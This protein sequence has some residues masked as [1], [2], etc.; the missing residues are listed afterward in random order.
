MR[1]KVHQL[2]QDVRSAIADNPKLVYLQR[3]KDDVNVQDAVLQQMASIRQQTGVTPKFEAVLNDI[4]EQ[5]RVQM[6]NQHKTY[7]EIQKAQAEG[8]QGSD[9]GSQGSDK[10]SQKPAEDKGSQKP[11]ED[12]G[13]Q[14]SPKKDDKPVFK[15]LS[16]EEFIKLTEDEKLT[17]IEEMGAY[18]EAIGFN[19]FAQQHEKADKQADKTADKQHDKADKQTDKADKQ[20][21]KADKQ[22]DKQEDNSQTLGAGD[23]EN[24]SKPKENLTEDQKYN[25]DLKKWGIDPDASLELQ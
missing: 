18:E 12:K 14:P 9:K 7:T 21:D 5:T 15:K 8:S 25:E 6:E 20:T 23:G 24:I 2:R 16:D 22:T 13:S 1:Q 11:A 17:Y 4:N 3:I 10:G 19:P